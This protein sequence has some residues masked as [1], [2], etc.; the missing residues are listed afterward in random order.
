MQK[1]DVGLTA[2]YHPVPFSSNLVFLLS[3]LY[4]V[5]SGCG[6]FLIVMS[7]LITLCINL[8]IILETISR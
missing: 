3:I 7:C 8:M 5:I 1:V 4:F 6:F 2:P